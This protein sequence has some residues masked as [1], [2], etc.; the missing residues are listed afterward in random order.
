[1]RTVF[2]ATYIAL[3]GGAALAIAALFLN[4]TFPETIPGTASQLSLL[5]FWSIV[6]GSVPGA[7]HVFVAQGPLPKS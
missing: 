3:M 6:A 5:A 4:S 2:K 7:V 1:M